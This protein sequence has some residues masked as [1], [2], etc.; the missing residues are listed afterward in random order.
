MHTTTLRKVGGS[1]MLSVPPALL[2]ILHL[3]PG[4]MAFLCPAVFRAQ[5]H[6]VSQGAQGRDCR[7]LATL[8]CIGAFVGRIILGGSFVEDH[9]PALP[10]WYLASF[11]ASR[12]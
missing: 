6:Y 1:V 5:V 11:S 2:D 8:R 4:A 3:R 10:C 9:L 12:Q 7:Q